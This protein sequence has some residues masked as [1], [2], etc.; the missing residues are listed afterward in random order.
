M[1]PVIALVGR[2]NVGKS[3]LFNKLTRSRDALVAD[4]PGLTRD[5]I[6]GFGK[7][8]HIPYIVIDTGGIAGGEQGID[9]AMA[10]QTKIALE[11]ADISIIMVDGRSGLTSADE[12][13][14]DLCRRHAK[15]IWLAVNKTEGLDMAIANSEFHAVT[16]G[17]DESTTNQSVQYRVFLNEAAFDVA[18]VDCEGRDVALS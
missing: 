13:V 15:K 9:E 2:P 3:T 6:Y 17:S 12:Y 14:A 16:S 1:L 8:G 10:E 11:E 7:L 5:R 4:Y 18:Y